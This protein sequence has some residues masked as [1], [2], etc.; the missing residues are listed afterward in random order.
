MFLLRPYCDRSDGR[1][2]VETWSNPTNDRAT[3]QQ[4]D[5]AGDRAN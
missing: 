2:W 1:V 5:E 4:A 3:W